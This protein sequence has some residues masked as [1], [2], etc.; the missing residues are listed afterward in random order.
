VKAD[1]LQHRTTPQAAAAY[2]LNHRRSGDMTAQEARAFQVWLDRDAANRAAYQELERL[3]GVLIA[4]VDD[5]EVIA[6]REHDARRFDVRAR[7]RWVAVAASVLVLVGGGGLFGARLADNPLGIPALSRHELA[8][9]ADQGTDIG[10]GITEF[11]TSVGQRTTVTLP[12]RSVVTLDTDTVLRMHHTSGERRVSLEQ[13]RAFF[14]VAKDPSRPFIVAAGDHLVRAIGTAFDVRV[15]ADHFEV[16]LVEG[17]VKVETPSA[18]REQPVAAELRPGQRLAVIE[19]APQLSKVDLRTETSWHVGRLTFV[20]DPISDAVEEMNRY[21][22]KKIFFQGG[23]APD[24]SIIGVFR[25]GDVDSFAK[26]VQMEGL[27]TVTAETEDFIE[28]RAN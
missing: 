19:S 21:S 22:E 6:A 17:R 26:A 2:W 16:T 28:L 12:D 8:A 25:A 4:A 20:R 23:Q 5:P 27:A 10:E 15:D 18:K 9:P 1:P 7:L 3:W 13:G 11:R 14:R 24:K